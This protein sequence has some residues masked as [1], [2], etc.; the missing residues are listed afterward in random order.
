MAQ[1]RQREALL[2]QLIEKQDFLAAAEIQVE[3]LFGKGKGKEKRNFKIILTGVSLSS[4]SRSSQEGN[5][6][7]KKPTSHLMRLSKKPQKGLLVVVQLERLLWLFR[8][9]KQKKE[10]KTLFFFLFFFVPPLRF[11]FPPGFFLNVDENNNE[12]S[13]QIW[14]FHKRGPEKIVPRRRNQ[15]FLPWLPSCT[16]PGSP[17]SIW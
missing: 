17:F 12:C 10:R 4:Q 16:P 1:I 13:V 5:G 15:T 3:S 7:K 8:F 14:Y 2:R 9:K 11:C 6:R